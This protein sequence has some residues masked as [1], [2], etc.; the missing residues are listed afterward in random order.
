MIEENLKLV[1]AVLITLDARAPFS[2]VNPSLNGLLNG[3]PRIYVLNKA[4]LS[5]L[6][7]VEKWIEYFEG[8]KIPAVAVDSTRTNSSK[9]ISDVLRL[10]TK[11]KTQKYFKKGVRVP[12][13][14][15]VAGVPNSGKSTVINNFC[16]V[17]KAATGDRPGITRGKQWLK[18]GDGIELLDTPGIL[19]PNLEDKISSKNLAYI[20]SIKDDVLDIFE[21]ALQFLEDI[22]PA[23]FETL[24]LRYKISMQGVGDTAAALFEEICL[25]RGFVLRDAKID[26]ERGARAIIDDFRKGRLGKVILETPVSRGLI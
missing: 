17:K 2:C 23:Y 25:K 8:I 22:K 1:D 7:A 11:D 24:A 14:A 13:R 9:V 16:G 12:V 6:R 4:D 15:M 3:K 10:S 19:S 20:G 26:T 5:D 18:I 21:L